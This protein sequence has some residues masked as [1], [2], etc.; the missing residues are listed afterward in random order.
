M[1][2]FDGIVLAVPR[3][4]RAAATKFSQQVNGPWLEHGALRVVRG[5]GVEIP[6]GSKTDFRKAVQAT[7]DEE[8]V[9]GWVEWPD[10]ATRDAAMVKMRE[11]G[12]ERPVPPFDA[13]RIVFGGFEAF[14]DERSA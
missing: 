14:Y 11:A 1:T 6:E 2:Y 3:A 5:W 13:S 9:F 12:G 4:N 8:I 7:E 10:K